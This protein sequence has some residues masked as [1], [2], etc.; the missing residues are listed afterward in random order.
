V[1]LT[2]E[3]AEGGGCV[4]RVLDRGRGLEPGLGARVFEPGVTTKPAGS[5]L[6]LTIARSLARQHGG[7]LA[8]EARAGGGTAAVLR[9]P[10]APPPD[11]AG[12][13][14]FGCGAAA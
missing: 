3:A 2:G 12:R 5:G 4:L 14:G 9:L 11:A 1:T 13:G 7:D 6:G 10:G 8:L